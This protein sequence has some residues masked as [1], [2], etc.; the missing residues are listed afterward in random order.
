MSVSPTAAVI[1]LGTNLSA[2]PAP[3]VMVW[4]AAWAIEA[5]RR[6][7]PRTVFIL[8]EILGIGKWYN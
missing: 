4:V 1:S 7:E 8:K 3:T 2:L 5:Q 6:M